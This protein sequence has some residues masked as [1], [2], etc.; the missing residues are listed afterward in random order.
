MTAF[1]IVKTS[2]VIIVCLVNFLQLFS[3]VVSFL[4]MPQC[5]PDEPETR[6]D[7]FYELEMCVFPAVSLNGLSLGND[8]VEK[9]T[10][11]AEEVNREPV[12]VVAG[13][14]GRQQVGDELGER[15]SCCIAGVALL[16][17][18]PFLNFSELNKLHLCF[19]IIS[20]PYLLLNRAALFSSYSEESIAKKRSLY[21]DNSLS[22][23]CLTVMKEVKLPATLLRCEDDLS[24]GN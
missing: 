9:V 5:L 1:T 3:D 20:S 12:A 15:W 2:L 7:N 17:L 24:V 19:R 16:G 23:G 21:A 4:L 18:L 13:H 8:S 10:R 11:P 22:K 14:V 6:V